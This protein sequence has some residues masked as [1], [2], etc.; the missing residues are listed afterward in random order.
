MTTSSNTP[1]NRGAAQLCRRR[2]RSFVLLG[3]VKDK[4]EPPLCGD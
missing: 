3:L 4:G 1:Y 2:T